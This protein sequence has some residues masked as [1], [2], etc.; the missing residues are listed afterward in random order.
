M[1]E[2]APLPPRIIPLAG[3]WA[4]NQ[5]Q[6]KHALA[7]QSNAKT[8]HY[9]SIGRQVPEGSIHVNKQP[10]MIFC[11]TR[12]YAKNLG[13]QLTFHH[14]PE[15]MNLFFK[16]CS[17]HQLN[18]LELTGVANPYKEASE[19]AAALFYTTEFQV[20]GQRVRCYVIGEGKRPCLSRL[21]CAAQPGWSIISAD[22]LT[23][24]SLADSND[25]P[26]QKAGQVEYRAQRDDELD[27]SDLTPES[28]HGWDSVI[29]VGLHS[30][31]DMKSFWNRIPSSLHRLMI[32]IPCCQN[33][34]KPESAEFF[35]Y[36]FREPSIQSPK[37]TVHIWVNSNGNVSDQEQRVTPSLRLRAVFDHLGCSRPKRAQEMELN[38]NK[39][40]CHQVSEE[41]L[42]RPPHCF[43][44]LLLLLSLSL[45]VFVTMVYFRISVLK[46][47][48]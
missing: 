8:T 26:S 40:N 45:M 17:L 37:R 9:F 21:I 43:R 42:H 48:E 35:V 1:S 32:A 10:G 47:G 7:E 22:P 23:S 16:I 25:P 41:I 28:G 18:L 27:L 30:H 5:K 3:R 46:L 24:Q 2:R 19:L 44:A 29:I 31:N 36:P 34:P 20:P 6:I 15:P 33:C 11:E 4:G 38:Q 14:N 13:I 39:G 12:G